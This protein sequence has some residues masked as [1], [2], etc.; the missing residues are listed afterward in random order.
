MPNLDWVT[1]PLVVCVDGPLRDQ[2]FLE[3]DWHERLRAENY[4]V[5]KNQRPGRSLAYLPADYTISHPAQPA[6]V[7]Q[8]WTSA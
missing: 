5:E 3:P 2:W 7:G 6:A 4:M 8:A 1:Q